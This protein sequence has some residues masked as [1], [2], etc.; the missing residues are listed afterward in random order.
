MD[1]HLLLSCRMPLLSLF[2]H[3]ALVEPGLQHTHGSVSVLQ[4]R[5]SLLTFCHY[6]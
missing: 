6:A 2:T 4:L 3:H 5:A 1:T